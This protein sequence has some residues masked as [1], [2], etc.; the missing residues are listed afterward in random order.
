MGHRD[1]YRERKR[2][3]P[4]G[5]EELGRGYMYQGVFVG[6]LLPLLGHGGGLLA[7]EGVDGVEDG[8]RGAS[9]LE[10]LEENAEALALGGG[11]A[12]TVGTEG[13][14]VSCVKGGGNVS[15]K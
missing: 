9:E 12:G 7:G 5:I 8:D 1:R 13:N 15:G 3:L 10:N 14:V 4:V 11:S 6:G 2:L